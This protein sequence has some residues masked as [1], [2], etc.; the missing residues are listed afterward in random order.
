M[1]RKVALVYYE[2]KWESMISDRQERDRDVKHVRGRKQ[3]IK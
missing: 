2:E 1:K 3:L